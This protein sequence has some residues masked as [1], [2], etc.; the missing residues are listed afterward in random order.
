LRPDVFDVLYLRLVYRLS[1]KYFLKELKM[2]LVYFLIFALLLLFGFA[3]SR[4]TGKNTK[5]GRKD[6]NATSKN[7]SLSPQLG[8]SK[9]NVT[10]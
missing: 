2:S 10:N 6:N 4:E 1:T 8:L 5:H 9:V 3:L 7:T